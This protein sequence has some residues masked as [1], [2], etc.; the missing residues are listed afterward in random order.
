MTLHTKAANEEMLNIFNQPLGQVSPLGEQADAADDSDYD[1]DDYTS[2]GDSTGTGH[3]SATNSEYGDEDHSVHSVQSNLPDSTD[4]KS[5]SE[6]SEFTKSK[7]VPALRSDESQDSNEHTPTDFHTGLEEITRSGQVEEKVE[8]IAIF[9]DEEPVVYERVEQ[10]GINAPD[11]LLEEQEEA[12]ESEF[13]PEA[14][15]PED[16]EVFEPLSALQR[17]PL[18][19]TFP[20]ED[21]HIPTNPY[22]DPEQVAQSRLPFMTPIVERTECSFPSV[23]AGGEYFSAKTPSRRRG[24]AD[25]ALPHIDDLL[26]SS[27]FQEIVND[28]RPD[29]VNRQGA[30]EPQLF[31]RDSSTPVIQDRQCNPLDTSIRDTILEAASS[32]LHNLESYRDHRPLNLGKGSELRK[33]SKA[34]KSAKSGDKS[35]IEPVSLRFP[36]SAVSFEIKREIGK[37]AFAPVYLA[38][39]GPSESNYDALAIKAEDP[40]SSWEFYIMTVTH[41]RL[42]GTRAAVSV[43]EPFGLELFGDEGYLLESYHDQGTLLDLS[44]LSGADAAAT[45]GAGLVDETVAMFF[46]VELLRTMSDLHEQGILHGDIKADNCLVRLEACPDADWSAVY[47]PSGESS[48]AAKGIFDVTYQSIRSD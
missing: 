3:I 36:G 12:E 10:L 43:A 44:N 2:G 29:R 30:R 15:S 7:H 41:D 26:L 33:F 27:P 23:K 28:A 11:G 4:H 17:L 42:S 32:Y 39:S 9:R 25:P 38:T 35:V 1:T 16:D 47:D 40:P 13:V 37:G 31:S 46:A 24:E 18:A 48:W 14:A 22:R 21:Y 34:M 19:M 6:W 8:P 5:V 20:S 45:G